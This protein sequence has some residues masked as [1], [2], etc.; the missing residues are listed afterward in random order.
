VARVAVTPEE[1]GLCGCWQVIA[2]QRETTD[3][4]KPAATPTV[5]IGYYASSL[6]VEQRDD[7][8]ILAILRGHWSAIENGTHYRRDV[9]LGED[10]CRTKDRNAA[11]V[12]ASLRNL[13]NGLYELE[14]A[15]QRTRVDTFRSWCQ[16]QTF[17]SAWPLLRR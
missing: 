5:E 4:S 10:A 2:V 7:Q 12:L 13:A 11:A 16:Q 15:R 1:I 6:T 14:R 3:L 9:T 8:P 17:S